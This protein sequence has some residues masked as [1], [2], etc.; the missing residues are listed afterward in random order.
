MRLHRAG[1]ALPRPTPCGGHLVPVPASLPLLQPGALPC[2]VGIRQTRLQVK[3]QC[4]AGTRAVH[5]RDHVLGPT[6]PGQRAPRTG[7]P[8][9]SAPDRRPVLPGLSWVLAAGQCRCWALG[10]LR[11]P[12]LHPPTRRSCSCPWPAPCRVP[13][14]GGARGVFRGGSGVWEQLAGGQGRVAEDAAAWGLG[15][16]RRGSGRRSAC[17]PAGTG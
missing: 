9:T 17:P 3:G 10:L 1:R 13:K 14:G 7:C 11:K 2:E 8:G 6:P 15:A 5:G 4:P 16:A 12:A